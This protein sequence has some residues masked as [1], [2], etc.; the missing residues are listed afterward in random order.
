MSDDVLRHCPQCGVAMERGEFV[1]KGTPR[2]RLFW[3]GL[4][5]S[6]F[7]RAFSERL[8]PLFTLRPIALSAGRC[9]TCRVGV[10]RY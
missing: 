3:V 2:P 4:G 6:L 7:R 8:G 9:R 10:V 1:I 5:A